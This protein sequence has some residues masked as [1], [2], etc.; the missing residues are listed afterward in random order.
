MENRSL[1]HMLGWYGK[2]NPN[3]DGR[4]QM[5]VPDLRKGKS[6]TVTS[7]SWGARG[8]KNFH[9]RGF[10][11]PSHGWDGGRYER[12]GGKLDG[13]LDARTNN[14]EFCMS[15]YDDIDVPVW[16]QLVRDYRSYDRYF[17]SL[18]G[19]T[20]P[21]RF[22]L[23]SG[24]SG[25]RKNNDLPPQVA[26]KEKD[27]S[28]VAGFTWPTIWTLFDRYGINANYFNSNLPVIAYWG[29]RHAGHIRHIS[30]YYAM[31]ATGTLP[32]VSVISPFFTFSSSLGNDDHPHADIRLGQAFLSDVIESF[33]NSPQ[34]EQSAMIVTYDEWG[35]FHD[36]VNPPRI[37]DD[38]GTPNDPGG[39]DDFGQIGFRVPTSVISPWTSTPGV[40]D[41][42][43]Y[44]HSSI[45]RFIADNWGLPYL[46]RRVASTTSIGKAF[47]NFGHFNPEHRF[48][49]YAVPTSTLVDTL[50]HS[51]YETAY[52][53]TKDPT[54]LPEVG[55]IPGTPKQ[56]PLPPLLPAPAPEGGPTIAA[57]GLELMRDKGWM[58]KWKIRTDYKL[59]DS[60]A[61]D[62]S[63]LIKA[64]TPRASAR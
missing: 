29:P 44:D 59:A 37:D 27:P 3:F 12:N 4:Q 8:T 33:V 54:K 60:F 63:K 17:C 55:K 6:G 52:E 45:V 50:R 24:Q 62:R 13:W 53:F 49:P 15:Y 7:R 20:Q 23:H 51:A 64:V 16:A 28:V 38:R 39:K 9:G 5:T 25:G 43:V 57:D 42:N 32:Q 1:D 19:P 22:Y 18:L 40:V 10:R 61:H 58:D 47:D 11:D 36:H 30:E 21:N 14:D 41:H 56:W 34:Y 31:C 2:E 35:G 48:E 46:T 26:Q